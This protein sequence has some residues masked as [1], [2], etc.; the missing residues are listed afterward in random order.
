MRVK[1]IEAKCVEKPRNGVYQWILLLVDPNSGDR[2][3]IDALQ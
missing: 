2:L 3:L 1:I